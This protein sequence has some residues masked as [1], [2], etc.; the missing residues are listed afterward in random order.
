MFDDDD[1]EEPPCDICGEPSCLVLDADTAHRQHFCN[2]HL[3]ES[4]NAVFRQVE[5]QPMEPCIVCGKPGELRII[6]LHA[7]AIR[8]YCGEHA[9]DEA[10]EVLEDLGQ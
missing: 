6:D 2:D 3:P 4:W 1:R 9:P 5:G 10:T 8:D 7:L